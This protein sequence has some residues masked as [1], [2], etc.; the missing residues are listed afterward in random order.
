MFLSRAFPGLHY[1]KAKHIKYF[2]VFYYRMTTL[3]KM[4]DI[5]ENKI[6]VFLFFIDALAVDCFMVFLGLSGLDYFIFL[7][8]VLLSALVHW[9]GIAIIYLRR[10]NK[11]S[12]FDCAFV[13][14]GI[15]IILSLMYC[16][17]SI[18]QYF[19]WEYRWFKLIGL[20]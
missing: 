5:P 10:R 17:I 12:F 9:V 8:I 1:K 7:R 18:W 15:F 13:R 20:R 4:N 2:L 14:V 11:M 6:F 3:H 19:A 16:F